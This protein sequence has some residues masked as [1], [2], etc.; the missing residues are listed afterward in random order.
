MAAEV[1]A[2]ALFDAHRD[3]LELDWV[4]GCG[5]ATAAVTAAD[6]SHEL[7]MVGPLNIIRPN[8]VQVI[9]RTEYEYL[10][11]LGKNS[12]QDVLNTL[13]GGAARLL[14]LADGLTANA[15]LMRRAEAARVPLLRSPLQSARVISHLQFFLANALAERVVAHGVM[16]D[17]MGIGV[18]LTGP[19][20]I[21]KSELALEL[22]TRGHRLVADDAPEFV[23][24]TPD[25]IH[26]SSPD[27]LHGFLE[28]RGLGILNI[29]AM[30]GDTAIRERKRLQLVI[31]LR[32][33]DAND[34]VGIDRLA[35]SRHLREVLD[36]GIPELLLPVAPGRNLAVIVE[37]AVRNH[38]LLLGGYNAAEDFVERQ[39]RYMEDGQA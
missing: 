35:G 6:S 36:V 34:L 20:G 11:S 5:E 12:R 4:A 13:F 23:R 22:I 25:T 33:L 29:R 9:G 2:Q 14:I 17:V 37:A 16:L 7:S 27:P 32:I 26:G 3:K 1:T 19:S 24:L 10:Q 39:R 15:E 28:V 8:Q 38:V 30:F 21:G 31:Q 18:L